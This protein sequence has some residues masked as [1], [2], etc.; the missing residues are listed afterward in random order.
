MPT[1]NERTGSLVHATDL[2]KPILSFT[3]TELTKKVFP[4]TVKS[5]V[6]RFASAL[7]SKDAPFKGHM[8]ELLKSK[9]TFV[10]IEFEL[11]GVFLK[12]IEKFQS[13]NL[14][15]L[16][17]ADLRTGSTSPPLQF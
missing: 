8:F 5:L 4:L 6:L 12:L 13:Y 15:Y 17:R 7:K 9:T 10:S 16:K 11:L 14:Y 2:N 1:C 3:I